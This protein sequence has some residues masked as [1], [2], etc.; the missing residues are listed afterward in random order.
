[1]ATKTNTATQIQTETQQTQPQAQRER[2]SLD[3][4]AQ[5]LVHPETGEI[6]GQ[7]IILDFAGYLPAREDGRKATFGGLLAGFTDP[8]S[9]QP[10]LFEGKNGEMIPGSCPVRFFGEDA[11]VLDEGWGER[12]AGCS[13][14]LALNQGATA[15]VYRA[16]D[17]GIM[18]L[19]L[20]TK[21]VAQC[22]WV[23]GAKAPKPKS[24]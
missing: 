15:A 20:G 22:G 10:C 13:F 2:I 8:V 1:M 3:T 24:F 5:D 4:Y 7:G 23:R 6:L 16:E 9:G 12:P 21:D 17:G 18:F 11:D 14:G 19:V